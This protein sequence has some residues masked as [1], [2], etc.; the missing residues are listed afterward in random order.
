M[1]GITVNTNISSLMAQQNLTT[2]QTKLAKTLERLS[3]GLRI[4]EAKDDPA[5]L[6]IAESMQESI[7]A[8]RKG[9]RN[10][11][12]GISLVQTAQGAMSQT[13]NILQRMREIA[14]QA[15]TGTYS[16]T[17]LANL[18]TEF[19]VL[20]SEVDRVQAVSTFNGIS[21]LNGG[22]LSIQVGENSTSND[23]LTIT[24]TDTDTTTLTITGG[25]VT[26]NAN[27][28]TALDDLDTAIESITT[29]LAQLGAAQSNLEAAIGSN[30]IRATNLESARSRIM[31]ADYAEESANL[32][33]YM[34]LNQ[35]NVAM[36]SQAN[37][38]PQLVLSLLK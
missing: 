5:G 11:N 33:K 6:A 37:S 2:N 21:V 24:L 27:A 10:G 3:S 25:D 28:Q 19:Q 38:A 8:L 12:D 18:D 16:S 20:M 7:R 13:L 29:G 23:R 1:A 15:S 30:D 4:T 31:D 17:D 26:S 35:S 34:I 32:A 9:S 14:S 22:S 36:L